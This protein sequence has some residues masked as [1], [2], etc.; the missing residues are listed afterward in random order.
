[1]QIGRSRPHYDLTGLELLR[2]RGGWP[3]VLRAENQD[4]EIAPGRLRVPC[5]QRGEDRVVAEFR[6]EQY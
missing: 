1:M 4:L 6:R 2:L 5:I 3:E